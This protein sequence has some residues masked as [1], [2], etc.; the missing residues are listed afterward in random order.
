MHQVTQ[1]HDSSNCLRSCNPQKLFICNMLNNSFLPAEGELEALLRANVA[2]LSC[3]LQD[4]ADVSIFF[5][6][7][8][9]S[10]AGDIGTLESNIPLSMEISSELE[11]E[12][13]SCKP[14]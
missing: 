3:I 12:V 6:M 7:A 14:L 4:V 1:G 8:F 9:E 2:A 11:L 5:E 10:S 13:I